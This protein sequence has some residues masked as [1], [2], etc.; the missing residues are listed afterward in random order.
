MWL[1]VSSQELH[2]ADVSFRDDNLSGLPAGRAAGVGRTQYADVVVDGRSAP[3]A[4]P[5]PP[6]YEET[7]KRK[8]EGLQ[9]V[10][11]AQVGRK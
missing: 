7:L 11:N 5:S 2:Y 3:S 9:S 6:S 4:G 1:C 10:H 8:Q